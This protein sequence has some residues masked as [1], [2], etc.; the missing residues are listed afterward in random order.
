MMRITSATSKIQE[1]I[2]NNNSINNS[3]SPIYERRSEETWAK[4]NKNIHAN[5][6]QTTGGRHL[7]VFIRLGPRK[8]TLGAAAG[9]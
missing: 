6:C 3:N 5:L 1:N 2:N 9:H 4:S 7:R 8:S